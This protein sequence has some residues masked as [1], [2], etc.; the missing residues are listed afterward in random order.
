M[1]APNYV[2]EIAKRHHEA[3]ICR[4]PTELSVLEAGRDLRGRGTSPRQSHVMP[5]A[6]QH[7][8]T[9][10][11][12]HPADGLVSGEVASSSSPRWLQGEFDFGGQLRANAPVIELNQGIKMARVVDLQAYRLKAHR[13]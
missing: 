4:M 3:T 11:Q 13:R 5:A 10:L 8:A 9:K 12:A 1:K 2:L 7:R 6:W